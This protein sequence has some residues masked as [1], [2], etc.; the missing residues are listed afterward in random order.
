MTP[1]SP[2]VLL[3]WEKTLDKLLDRTIAFPK[4]ARFTLTSRIDN[5]ALDIYEGLV[6]ARYA[7]EVTPLLKRVNMLLEK[8]RLLLRLAYKRRFLSEGAL[9]SLIEDIDTTGRMVGG[10]L[11]AG[12]Q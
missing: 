5:L 6:E 12:R 7:A 11:K 10:W 9:R 2:S 3:L 4:H 1:D 8:I